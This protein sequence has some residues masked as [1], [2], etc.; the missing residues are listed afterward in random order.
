VVIAEVQQSSDATLRLFDWNRVG[1]EGKPRQ[2]HIRESLEAI[3]WSAGPVEPKRQFAGF[4]QADR[5]EPLVSCP[6]F[7]MD[8]ITVTKPL[9]FPAVP[10]LRVCMVLSG[11]AELSA[12]D[13]YS[14][15]FRC[16]ETVLVPALAP[17][18]V[19]TPRGGSAMLIGVKC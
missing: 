7:A 2:L 13:S 6:Y 8:R 4:I 11:A 3:D 18:I 9:P 17:A 12:G 16:G 5:W 14:R 1:P 10:W 15:V 19:W